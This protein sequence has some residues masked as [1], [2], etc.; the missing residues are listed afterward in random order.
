MVA[1]RESW[2]WLGSSPC[3]APQPTTTHSP[4]FI[5]SSAYPSSVNQW[6]GFCLLVIQKHSNKSHFPA[7]IF[8][9]SGTH[10]RRCPHGFCTLWEAILLPYLSYHLK[11]TFCYP[12]QQRHQS[13]TAI[14]PSSS[15][16][17]WP[18]QTTISCCLPHSSPFSSCC[19]SDLS[20]STH[21]S[22][23]PSQTSISI[24]LPPWYNTK[25]AR[26]RSVHHSGLHLLL[27]EGLGF[28]NS[29]TCF[30]KWKLCS[31]ATLQ[32]S[33]LQVLTGICQ[34]PYSYLCSWAP[35]ASINFSNSEVPNPTKY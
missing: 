13:C 7:F 22:S 5:A 17:T 34:I 35:F 31:N 1:S 25:G 30:R 21:H 29:G 18:V 9:D 32:P 3:P 14:V 23:F 27:H 28:H 2:L 19:L 33:Q 10:A 20:S 12:W 26:S 15:S 11:V 4:S 24:S 16:Q 8:W 6:R